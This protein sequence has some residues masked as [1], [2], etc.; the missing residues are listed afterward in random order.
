MML[1]ISPQGA[2]RCVYAETV[3]LG[4]WVPCRFGALLTLNQTPR[5]D[6]LPT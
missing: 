5:G 6:G 4:C 1:V 2:L 3:D